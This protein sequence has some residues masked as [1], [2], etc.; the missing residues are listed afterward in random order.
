MWSSES[1][2]DTLPPPPASNFPIAEERKEWSDT[3]GRRKAEEDTLSC[4]MCCCHGV[5]TNGNLSA[6]SITSGVSN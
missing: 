3:E 5:Q 1:D 4:R 6:A 2:C